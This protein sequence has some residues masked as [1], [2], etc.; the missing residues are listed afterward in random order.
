[1]DL[2]YFLRTRLSFVDELYNSTVQ[3]YEDRKCKIEAHEEP[4]VDLRDP[5]YAD[6]PAFLE[7]WQEADDAMMVIGHWC[8]CMVHA[9]LKAYLKSYL[10]PVDVTADSSALD[11]ELRSTGGKSWF[12]RYRLLFLKALGVDWNS[13]PVKIGELE[14]LNLTRDDLIH[15]V[16]VLSLNVPMSADHAERFPNSLFTDDL[17]YGVP[18]G[19]VRIDHERLQLAIR[20]VLEFCGWLETFR[21]DTVRY[22]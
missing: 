7:E 8:F 9:S 22:F 4:Y 21:D 10:G 3:P 5:E 20:L 14:Q 13:G 1:V 6:E 12:E 18:G 19:R 2:L 11:R 17:W 16:D 15:N